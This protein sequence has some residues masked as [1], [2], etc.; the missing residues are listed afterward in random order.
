MSLLSRT[1]RSLVGQWWWTVDRFMLAGFATLAVF[2]IV[3][4]LVA[5]PHV[6][7]GASNIS[8]ESFFVVRHLVFLIPAAI[9]LVG[10]S[11]LA[12]R[13]VLRLA[14][15]MLAVSGLLLVGT[16][17]FAPEIK[18]AQRW[19]FILG[20]Q[21]Q[22]SEFVKPALAVV[23][24][25]LLARFERTGG[26]PEAGVLVGAVVAVL[27][28]QPD[29]GMTVLVCAVFAAQLFLAGIGWLWIGAMALGAVLL[30][31]GA[32]SFL[33]HVRERIT[34]FLDPES[35]VYQVEQAKLAMQSGGLTGRGPGEGTV[36]FHLPE[37]HTDFV[38]STAVEEFGAIVCLVVILV[39]AAI[40]MRGLLRVQ[41]TRDRFI[42]LASVGLLVQFGL[43]S[44]IN[45]AVNLSLM[46]TKG[47]TLPFISYGGSS[48]LALAIGMGML[49]S[50][51]RRGAHLRQR[52]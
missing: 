39:F 29:L 9:L 51:T 42:Q 1:N 33:P 8:R 50:L 34:G 7:R 52:R 27:L 6:A 5:S 48:M 38:F 2:G 41:A 37:P 10:T 31:V 15:V 30:L 44:I 23:V 21:L 40:V 4:V 19:V 3:M 18:G 46:P 11:I 32:Y 22:P 12:P 25:F 43:Q 16:L 26:L 24:A 14:V 47:M 36:K 20:L 49:L 13:G 35:E 45:M 28:L 17:F